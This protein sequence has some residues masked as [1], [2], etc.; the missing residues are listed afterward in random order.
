[1]TVPNKRLMPGMSSLE[2][3][4]GDDPRS[5][6]EIIAADSETVESLGRTHEELA[7]LLDELTSFALDGFGTPQRK[8]NLEVVIDEPIGGYVRCPF[9]DSQ[10]LRKGEVK[11]RNVKSGMSLVWTPLV[12]HLIRAHGFCQGRGARYRIE[13]EELVRI[14]EM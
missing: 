2:G 9:G 7:D 5:L 4:L 3:F 1:M 13:P 14:L 8:G 12:I 6:Q 11:L 10:S